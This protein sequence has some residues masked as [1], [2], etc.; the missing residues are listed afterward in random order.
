MRMRPRAIE[1]AGLPRNRRR[2]V[3]AAFL[4]LIVALSLVAAACGGGST[5]SDQAA[6][7]QPP[8]EP[9]QTTG[10]GGQTTETGGEALPG[11]KEFGLTEEEYAAHIEESQALIASCMAEAGFEYVPADVETVARAQAAVRFR[12]PYEQK[13]AYKEKWGYDASTR[14]ENKVKNIELGPQNLQYIRSLSEADRA[15]YERTLYGEDPNATFAFTFDE[16]DFSYT[17]GCTRAA[18]EQVFTP[19]Q[20]KG[21]Y[22]NPKDILI[23]SDPRIVEANANWVACM[24]EAGYDGYL[25]Q[26]EIIEEFE[27]RFFELTEG[28]DPR[29]LTGAKAEELKQLQAEEIAISLADLD[30]EQAL[31]KAVEEVEIELYGRP[32]S[33]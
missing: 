28:K 13:K 32:I 7:D 5:S 21:T 17:G 19:E 4:V 31:D 27:E 12:G 6:A 22:V 14:F 8:A 10:G 11:T 20:L 23:E 26:E 16:E 33:E 3:V 1:A 25:E 30:C 9:A 2:L 18:V 24:Q 15:A 29:T